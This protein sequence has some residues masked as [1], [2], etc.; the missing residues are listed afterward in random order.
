ME[1]TKIRD[2]ILA[3]LREKSVAKQNIYNT[4]RAEFDQLKTVLIY[5]ADEYNSHLNDCQEIS[6]QI[7][8]NGS[9]VV[10]LKVAGDMLVFVMHT[11]VFQFDRDHE[12]WKQPYI[13]ENPMRS[14]SGV[15]SIYNFLSDSFRYDREE[16]P[17]YLIARIFINQER[18]FFVEGKRQRRMGVNHFGMA[19]IDANAW[20]KIVETAIRYAINFDLLV[21]PY[22]AVNIITLNQMKDEIMNS[23]IKTGKRLGFQYN[24]DDVK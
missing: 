16:D 8:D 18:A 24:S 15:V 13:V 17:G 14:Y 2:S 19:T 22:E 21:P 9:Y 1:R 4:T 5:L 11:N 7:I 23:K 20:Q 12:V 3:T 10:Q 6:L